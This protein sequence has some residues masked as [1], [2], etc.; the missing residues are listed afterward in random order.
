[1]NKKLAPFP[2]DYTFF[3]RAAHKM[4]TNL[5]NGDFASWFEALEWMESEIDKR[6]YDICIIGCRAYGFNFAAHVKRSGKKAVHLGGV[7]ADPS[8]RTKNADS[9]EGACYW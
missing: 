5:T 8:Y 1:M 9:V 2:K 7:K 6:D 3:E 4:A